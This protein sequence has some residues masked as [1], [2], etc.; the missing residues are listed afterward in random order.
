MRYLLLLALILIAT[1]A[2]ADKECVG[3]TTLWGWTQT[4]SMP[5]GWNVYVSRNGG[6]FVLE[7]SVTEMEASVSGVADETIAVQV[8]ATIAG[9]E[10]PMSIASETITLRTLDAPTEVLIKCG[11]GLTMTDLGNG[12]W[13]C[14]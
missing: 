9:F 10:S 6:P 7:Q 13:S 8:S 11:T 1:P 14:Q 3:D 12:W 2:L 5:T 4:G